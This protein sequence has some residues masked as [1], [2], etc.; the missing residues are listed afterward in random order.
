MGCLL[1]LDPTQG[2]VAV[3]GRG[4]V[5]LRWRVNATQLKAAEAGA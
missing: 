2:E 5:D 4:E 3:P 1:A